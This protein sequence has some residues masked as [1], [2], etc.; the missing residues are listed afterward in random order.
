YT[1]R[2][3]LIVHQKL[4]P[5]GKP[6]V[7]STPLPGRVLRD[8]KPKTLAIRLLGRVLRDPTSLYRHTKKGSSSYRRAEGVYL[9]L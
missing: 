4:T 3:P 7:L 1:T 9:P 8:P 2:I 6:K 5:V